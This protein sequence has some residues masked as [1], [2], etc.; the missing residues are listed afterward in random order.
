MARIRTIKPE[1][2]ANEKV[3]NCSRGSRLLFIGLWNF[4]DDTGRLRDSAKSIKAQIFPGDDD[5]NSEIVRGMIDELSGNGLVLK[6]EVEGEAYLEVTGW[7][8]QR[9]DKPH[10]SKHPPP[11]STN[12]PRTIPPDL[13]YPNPIGTNLRRGEHLTARPPA[14]ALPTGA[15]AVEPTPAQVA[16]RPSEVSRAELDARIAARRTG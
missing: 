7:N 10:P 16:K 13:I 14:T 3:M 5:V 9:I 11:N 2:W 8:H 1:F 15:R 4:A 12:V 6:Y